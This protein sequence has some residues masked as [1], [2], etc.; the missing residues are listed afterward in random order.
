[1]EI[2]GKRDSLLK[3]EMK[4]IFL[5]L[6]CHVHYT[7]QYK[8]EWRVNACNKMKVQRVMYNLSK[9]MDKSVLPLKFGG[10]IIFLK[11]N[12]GTHIEK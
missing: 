6:K 11:L 12:Y 4:K 8:K 7:H 3:F 10:D 2:K 5:S 9:F 1:M